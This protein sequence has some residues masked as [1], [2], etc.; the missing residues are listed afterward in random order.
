M[1]PLIEQAIEWHARQSSGNFGDDEHTRFQQWLSANPA[2]TDAWN[3]LQQ[4]LGK[5]LLPL[6]AAP[7]RQALNTPN[8]SRRNLLRGTLAISTMAVGAHLL[9]KPGMPLNN[10]N[11]DLRTQTAERRRIELPSA[12]LTLNAQ[13]AVDLDLSGERHLVRLHQGSLVIDTQGRELSPMTLASRFGEIQL[14][15]GRCVLELHDDFARACL[16]RGSASIAGRPLLPGQ[17]VH[18]LA[19]GVTGMR[20]FVGAPDAWVNGFLQAHDWTLGQLIDQLRPYHRGMLQLSQN[21]AHL[22]ISGV[23][24]LDNSAQALAAL[25]DILPVRVHSYLG[26]WTRIE[27]V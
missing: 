16:L 2:H 26:V 21:A 14:A 23:F 11:A 6:K 10:W 5:T 12:W 15:D 7:A 17:Q 3:A 4:R 24:N 8:L 9:G 25:A 20:P 19:N 27:H 22:R 18:M 1:S 13:S